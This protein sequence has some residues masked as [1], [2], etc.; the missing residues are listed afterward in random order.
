M[1][2]FVNNTTYRS[3]TQ[4]WIIQ[5]WGIDDAIMIHSY[6][7]WTGIALDNSTGLS[8]QKNYLVSMIKA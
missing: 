7:A 4:I 5:F 6:R 8:L 2:T 1:I 3:Y